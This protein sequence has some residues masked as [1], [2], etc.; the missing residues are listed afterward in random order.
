MSE[1]TKEVLR[2]MIEGRISWDELLGVMRGEKEPDRFR[3]Y[4]EVLQERVQW[5]ERILLP[6]AEHLYIVQKAD[7]AR[8]VKCDCGHEFCDYRENWKLDALI[9]VR[10]TDAAI[11]KIYPRPMGCN[12]EW[13]ELREYLCPGCQTQLD[14]E[15]VPPGYPVVFNFLPD[16]D[17]FYR[18]WLGEALEPEFRSGP[19][20]PTGEAEARKGSPQSDD[21]K[22]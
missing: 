20:Q 5:Q 7:G 8:I 4:L 19:P 22:S 6:L 11:N 12:S 13:M 2:R 17:A 16:L 3:K 15:A 1:P 21:L 14:V 18:H 10:N 9:N